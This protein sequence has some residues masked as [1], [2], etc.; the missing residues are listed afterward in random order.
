[1]VLPNELTIAVPGLADAELRAWAEDS[2]SSLARAVLRLF[3]ERDRLR[4]AAEPLLA[5]L[6]WPDVAAGVGGPMPDRYALSWDIVTED[7]AADG[8]P[9]PTIGDLRRLAAA[10]AESA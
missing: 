2:P 3:D 9:M 1:M 4:A 5:M 8:G 6:E 7:E 10:L